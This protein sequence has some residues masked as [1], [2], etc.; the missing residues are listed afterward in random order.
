ME[1]VA[2]VITLALIEYMYI[3]MQVGMARGKYGVPA[4]AITGDPTF[5]RY[6]RVQQNT[7]EQMVIFLPSILL[8]AH[9][10]MPAAAAALGLVFI[11][12]RALYFKGYVAA[13]EKRSTGFMLTFVPNV[14]LVLGA[15]IGAIIAAV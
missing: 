4:P 1:L 9:F 14:I 2:I 8:F 11:V 7:V 5:E 6:Y 13:P 15:L 10:V 12:G 3:S